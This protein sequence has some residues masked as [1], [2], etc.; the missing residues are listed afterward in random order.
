MVLTPVDNVDN[1]GD[2]CS[3][4]G[5]TSVSVVEAVH[6]V[7]G[8]NTSPGCENLASSTASRLQLNNLSAAFRSF[9]QVIHTVGKHVYRAF[10]P[11]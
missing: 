2:A 9:P 1:S 5:T 11:S 8:M 10:R 6:E 4:L 7:K 3:R